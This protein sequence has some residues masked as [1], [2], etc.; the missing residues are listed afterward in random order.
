MHELSKANPFPKIGS[1]VEVLENS[2]DDWMYAKV[3]FGSYLDFV[4]LL[5]S[6]V[7]SMGRHRPRHQPWEEKLAIAMSAN[8]LVQLLLDVIFEGLHYLPTRINHLSL[9]FLNAFISFKTL[10]AISRNR[11][12]FLHE[13]CQILWLMEICLIFGDVYYAIFDEY[14]HRFLYLRLFFVI[15]S[16]F[17]FAGVTW[18]M[19][20]YQLWSLS[21]KGHEAPPQSALLRQRSRSISL[22]KEVD[23]DSEK[24]QRSVDLPRVPE[25]VGGSPCV[26]DG[27]IEAGAEVADD[28]LD[29]HVNSDDE[30][31]ETGSMADERERRMSVHLDH[32][33]AVGQQVT[34]VAPA[35]QMAFTLTRTGSHAESKP[36]IIPDEDDTIEVHRPGVSSLRLLDQ[37]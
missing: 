32:Q 29:L 17:N 14:S 16:L 11:F 12:S 8:A 28:N 4:A 5:Y 24:G 36:R 19:C 15:C 9:T 35:T 26:V 33:A 18:I 25:H 10:S 6:L 27:S 34:Q 22:T 2:E 21:Y 30:M 7:C 3:I 1:S 37:V 13:D 31:D 20:R 23:K